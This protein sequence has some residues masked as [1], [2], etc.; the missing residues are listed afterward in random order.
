M[1]NTYDAVAASD[2]QIDLVSVAQ[3]YALTLSRFVCDLLGWASQGLYRLAEGL[4]QGSSIMPQK[5]NPVALEHARTRFSRAL[6]ASQ[7]VVFSSHN[8]P[9][10]D[11][12][13]FG[14]DIQGALQTLFLQLHGGLDLLTASVA[15]GAF[16]AAALSRLAHES[17][18][19]ATELADELVR[20]H[21]LAFQDAHHLVARLIAQLARQ[22]RP[23]HTTTPADLTALGG[24]EL[25]Q[26]EI[27]SALDPLAFI[28]RRSGIGG[29]APAVVY[30]QLAEAKDLLGQHRNAVAQAQRA[31]ERVSVGLTTKEEIV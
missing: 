20:R 10:G 9:F 21:G 29:P 18:T 11:L 23:L 15:T 16:D 28:G 19:T 27:D 24:P 30:D 26:A 4:V 31:L 12:N 5:R 6:G 13:D 3:Q 7:M 2:W 22:G 14:P 25:P 1:G 8:I 17:D